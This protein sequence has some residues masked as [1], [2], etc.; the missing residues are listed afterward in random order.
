MGM[1][2]FYPIHD[3][4][5][6]FTEAD[7][8]NIASRNYGSRFY[9]SL[10]IFNETDWELN[11][12]RYMKAVAKDLGLSTLYGFTGQCYKVSDD[13]LKGRLCGLY[14]GETLRYAGILKYPALFKAAYG[15]IDD[16][17]TEFRKRYRNVLPADFNYRDRLCFIEGVVRN[18]SNIH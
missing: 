4:G 14:T 6:V 15:S 13:G 2:D 5:V 7:I 12:Y 18:N 16:V 9:G 3:Y 17:I 1:L 10:A 8:H 11:K